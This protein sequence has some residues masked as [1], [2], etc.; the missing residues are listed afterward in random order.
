MSSID[1]NLGVEVDR[2]LEACPACKAP[3]NAATFEK[4]RGQDFGPGDLTVCVHCITI[5]KIG[6]QLELVV[7]SGDDLAALSI[8]DKL[9]VIR[10]Q[11][12]IKGMKASAAFAN[13]TVE[14]LMQEGGPRS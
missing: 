11:R 10:T 3:L 2:A 1:I 5:L 9:R 7:A 14:K 12:L 4:G 6:E 8:E 13:L